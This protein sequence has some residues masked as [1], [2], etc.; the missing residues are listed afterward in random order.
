M[1][2]ENVNDNRINAQFQDFYPISEITSIP[3]EISVG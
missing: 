3:T 2:D 1:K